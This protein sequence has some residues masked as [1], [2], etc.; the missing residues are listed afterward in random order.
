MKSLL[1]ILFIIKLLAR[2]DIFKYIQEK[3]GHNT[4]KSVRTYESLKTKIMKGKADINFMKSCK[5]K[6]VI[7]TFA[8]VRISI[9]NA[10]YKLRRKIARLIVEAEIQNKH[11]HLRKLKKE[12]KE[13]AIELKQTL[14][15]FIFNTMVYR[16]NQIITSR[17]FVVKQRH[18]KKL[19]NLCEQSAQYNKKENYLHNTVHNFS[20]Y[21]L[22]QD[23]RIAL[24]FGL[25]QHIPN[26]PVKHDIDTEFE[27]FYHSLQKDLTHLDA[28]QHTHLKTKLRETCDKYSNIQIPYKYQKAISNLSKNDNIIILKQDKGRGV[29]IMDRTKYLEKCLNMLNT[30]Q[31]RK[32]DTDPTQSL[33]KKVKTTL[34]KLISI[35]T[36]TE[37]KKLYPTGSNPGKFY[38]TA[39]IHKLKQD[40]GIDQLTLRPIISN[41]GTATYHTAKYLAKLL[42]PLS[43]SK[44]TVKSTT[45]FIDKLKNERVPRNHTLVSFDVKSLFTNVPL[46]KTIDIILR[47]IYKEKEIHTEIPRKEMK[48]LLLLCTKNVHFT[49]N[50]ETYQQT[51]GVAMGSPLGPV[52]A[53]IFMV[54]LENKMVPKLKKSL[55][56]WKRYVDDTLAY[57][58]TG[59]IE[60]VLNAINSFHP[61]IQF[62]YEEE[63]DNSIA[64]L[65]VYVTRIDSVV[66]TTVYRK[67]T[68]NDIYLNWNSFTP[69]NWKKGTLKMLINRAYKV[70]SN[71]ELL[72]KEL[73]HLS[74]AFH[75][76]NDYPMWIIKQQLND[77]REIHLSKMKEDKNIVP[78]ENEEPQEEQKSHMIL[79]PYRGTKGEHIIRGM[80]KEINRSLPSNVN[81]R[82][83]YKGT[84]LSQKFKVKDKT[85][86]K[87]S[88]NLVY[89]VTCPDPECQAKY[90]GETA[91]R[92]NERVKDHSGRDHA[93]YVLKHSLENNHPTVT[94]N[95]FKIIGNNPRNRFFR[96][97]SEALYIK[98]KRP[99]LNKQEK[100]VPIKLLN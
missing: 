31:F 67:P 60:T 54:E 38:G 90:I 20:S 39:K 29:V 79:L 98:Q 63:K 65:D 97:I 70:C 93:S 44:Y 13:T 28:A 57:V 10:N 16:I 6:N 17:Y 99:Q 84:K 32:L 1:V 89:E 94:L 3:H 22:T 49:F 42:A 92:I 14:G 64:F 41:I 36:K 81:T 83:T 58:K 78:S 37:Y 55:K 62:T 40:E 50:K 56:H 9:K 21:E 96:K 4:I 47:R 35:F 87:H 80:T 23:E 43:E 12:L 48:E 2:K 24:S 71:D 25:D 53:G 66:S 91:R 45:D 34:R 73:N 7:P 27:Q 74:K 19:Q 86:F 61:S 95:D 5:K 75:E 18:K 77:A 8:K 15:I 52:L 30:N 68:S 76:V 72:Q 88:H 85:E 26:K 100:S 46:D 59:S 69:F 11:L 33:E 82:V 51:D